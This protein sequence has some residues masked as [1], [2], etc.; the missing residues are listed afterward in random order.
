M[1]HLCVRQLSAQFE[2]A[3]SGSRGTRE[4]FQLST[5]SLMQAHVDSGKSVKALVVPHG[6]GGS[7]MLNVL[8]LPPDPSMAIVPSS[9]S[10]TIP[11]CVPNGTP[12]S[13]AGPHLVA[14]RHFVRGEMNVI[15][16]GS[17]SGAPPSRIPGIPRS[18]LP[19]AHAREDR[20]PTGRWRSPAGL[21][22]TRTG[23]SRPGTRSDHVRTP[24]RFPGS[25]RPNP[26]A[27]L[28]LRALR[29]A[30]IPFPG[31]FS[32]GTGSRPKTPSRRWARRS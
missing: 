18:G 9:S 19:P 15:P 13:L 10:I 6:I 14:I 21:R 22:R 29:Q 2:F 20:G 17:S 31:T 27:V 23:S 4:R 1:P 30:R 24:T 8:M 11:Q 7:S 3:S 25:R 12:D 32:P 16:S 26:K 28:G 5:F